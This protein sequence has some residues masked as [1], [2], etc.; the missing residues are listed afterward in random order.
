MIIAAAQV[1]ADDPETRLLVPTAKHGPFLPFERCAETAANRRL[2]EGLHSH[3]AEEVLTYVLEG[4][5]QHAEQNGQLTELFPGSVLLLTA[6]EELRHELTVQ[7]KDAG[8]SARWFSIVLRLP[9]HTEPPPTSLQIREAGEAIQALDGTVQRPV[10]GPLAR[11]ESMMGL[12]CTDIEFARDGRSSFR[13]G[14]D[15]RAVA[16]ALRGSGTVEKQPVEAGHGALL[17]NLANVTIQGSRGYRVILA[18]VPVVR[19]ETGAESVEGRLRGTE[20]PEEDDR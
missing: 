6:H 3:S 2:R 7:A 11:A 13:I 4:Y 15:R 17:E 1:D 9:W 8:G 14:R 10:V 5:V 18:T 20:F 16:Y 12:E 19:S